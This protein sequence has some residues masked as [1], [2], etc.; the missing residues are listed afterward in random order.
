[1]FYNP[2]ML[3]VVLTAMPLIMT[4]SSRSARAGHKKYTELCLFKSQTPFFMSDELGPTYENMG[5]WPLQ[6]NCSFHF[7][8]PE[9]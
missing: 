8:P 9:S 3:T 5:A 7:F 6:K 1:M 4:A 2:S